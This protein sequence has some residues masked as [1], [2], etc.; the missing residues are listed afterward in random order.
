M[1]AVR[2]PARTYGA[3]A[4]TLIVLTICT[5]ALTGSYRRVRAS[6][7]ENHFHE[8]RTLSAA[9]KSAEAIEEFR[10]AMHLAPMNPQYRLELATAVAD[11]GLWDEAE[12][13]FAELREKDPTNGLVN[14]MSARVAAKRDRAEAAS[15]YYQ[16]A[17]YGFWQD[18]RDRR[19]LD[20]RLEF[21]RYLSRAGRSAQV[22]GQV[23][24]TAGETSDP[25]LRSELAAIL[26]RHGSAQHAVELLK[27]TEPKDEAV[28][29]QLGDAYFATGQFP[30]AETAY[31]RAL[32]LAP[33][34]PAALQKLQTT[35]EVRSIDP[36]QVRLT[37]RERWSRSQQVL[38]RATT[39]LSR[40]A[41]V[42]AAVLP[43]HA[44]ADLKSAEAL[45]K[46][47][48]QRGAESTPFLEAADLVWEA[49]QNLCAGTPEVDEPLTVLMARLGR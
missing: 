23:L 13:R 27:E 20:A 40:C 10:A 17:I 25:K 43:D 30:G 24:E 41:A 14:L 26:L 22:V 29:V 36:T 34:D 21:V 48:Y 45:L 47:R 28:W 3:I 32:R 39:A 7:A 9:G 19:R 42:Q 15:R 6:R 44:A 33:R 11:A 31:R 4:V 16:R 1:S 38:R 35:S 12:L 37:S 2:G 18:E 5:A 8:G 49:R 46:T